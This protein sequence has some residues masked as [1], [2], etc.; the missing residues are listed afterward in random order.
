MEPANWSSFFERHSGLFSAVIGLLIAFY[1]RRWSK[2]RVE[3][4]EAEDDLRANRDMLK[5][6][7]VF[8][9][10]ET[11]DYT[12]EQDEDEV[13]IFIPVSPSL[14]KRDVICEFHQ[15][16]IS[17][18]VQNNP[19]M[20]GNLWAEIDLDE[21]TWEF[22]RAEKDN[23]T[24]YITLKKAK[25]TL[26]RDQ[27]RCVVKGHVE[28]DPTRLGPQIINLDQSDPESIKRAV[29]RAKGQ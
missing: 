15:T 19:V 17:V 28:L 2:S 14:T 18:V 23:P 6:P 22:D 24:I 5:E 4:E 3:A 12:W 1:I 26:V 11:K 16:R 29:Q 10:G 20:V 13:Y 8:Y 27:W 7:E 21:S 9:N 25:P